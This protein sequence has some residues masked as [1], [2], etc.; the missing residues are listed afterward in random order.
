MSARGKRPGPSARLNVQV[1]QTLVAELGSRLAA[2]RGCA[3]PVDQRVMA[4]G[5]W[6]DFVRDSLCGWAGGNYQQTTTLGYF[7]TFHS[8]FTD[9]LR[10]PV[11]RRRAHAWP[12]AVPFYLHSSHCV[13]LGF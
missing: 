2:A 5:I 9:T 7:S 12:V 4:L 10:A 6:D 3:C 8:E 1:L 11:G 13:P